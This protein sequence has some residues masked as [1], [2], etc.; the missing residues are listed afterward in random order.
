[1]MNRHRKPR[2]LRATALSLGCTLLPACILS[3]SIGDWDDVPRPLPGD[4]D[5]GAMSTMAAVSDGE[6]ETAPSGDSEGSD[7]SVVVAIDEDFDAWD[8]E[9]RGFVDTNP[10]SPSPFADHATIRTISGRECL[11]IHNHPGDNNG[12]GS[13]IEFQLDLDQRTDMSGEDF[14]ISF[15]VFLPEALSGREVVLQFA[16]FETRYYTPI[17]SAWF[18][19]FEL[20]QWETVTAP[21]S[22][23]AIDFSLFSDNPGDWIFD[24]VR[25]ALILPDEYGVTLGPVSVCFDNLIVTRDPA[26]I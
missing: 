25:L 23:G 19:D 22:I 2:I 17:Y 18:T 12:L 20:D 14:V 26:R 15:D 24:A 3:T 13:A 4:T 5:V 21:I 1:M 16:F 8:P 10:D 9:A 7:G 11:F 6:S